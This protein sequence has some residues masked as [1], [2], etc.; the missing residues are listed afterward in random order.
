MSVKFFA[1]RSRKRAV[2]SLTVSERRSGIK[3]N[4]SWLIFMANSEFA[5]TFYRYKLLKIDS[6]TGNLACA[7]FV[8]SGKV[9]SAPGK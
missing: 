7:P 3:L 8:G 5:K 1:S 9:P 2:S 4:V 6:S